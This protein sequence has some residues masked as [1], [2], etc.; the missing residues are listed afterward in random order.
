MVIVSFPQNRLQVNAQD[1]V[2]R[3]IS[4]VGSLVGRNYQLREMLSFVVKHGVSARVNTFLFHELNE[5][6][7]RSKQGHGGKLVVGMTI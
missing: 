1:L 3:D 6:L 7:Q 4:L 5:L 2:F